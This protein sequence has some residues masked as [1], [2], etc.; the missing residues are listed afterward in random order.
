LDNPN[1]FAVRDWGM[2]YGVGILGFRATIKQRV[3]DEEGT[4]KL[5]RRKVRKLRKYVG[6]IMGNEWRYP[7]AQK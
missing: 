4:K 1:I 6:K 3:R 5:A 7:F 2:N